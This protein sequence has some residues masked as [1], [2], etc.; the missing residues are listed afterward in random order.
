MTAKSLASVA[1]HRDVAIV[2]AAMDAIISFDRAGCVMEYNPAAE[3]LLGWTREETLGKHLSEL[4]TPEDAEAV[5]LTGLDRYLATGAEP[6]LDQRIEVPGRRR[7]GQTIHVEML[8]VRTGISD[9][10]GFTIFIRDIT[11]LVETRKRLEMSQQRFEAIVRHSRRI[12]ILCAS[13]TEPSH[14]IS[15]AEILGYTDGFCLANGFRGIVHPDDRSRVDRYVQEL[16]SR[17]TTDRS[18]D[19]R[20]QTATHEWRTCEVTGEDL[21]ELAAIGGLLISADDVT[22]ERA[23]RQQLKDRTAQMRALIN[24]LGSAVVLEDEHRHLLVVNERMTEMFGI[25]VSTDDLIGADCARSAEDVKHLFADPAG[26]VAR[27]DEVLASGER[28]MGE[29]L[30][31]AD[32]G[33]LERDYVPILS[34]QRS[35]GHLWVYRDITQQ[36]L[37]TQLLADQNRSLEEL[38]NLKNEFVARVSHELRSPLTSVASFADLLASADQ[39]NLGEDQQAFLDIIQRNTQ[40]LLR[41]IE[42]LLLVAKLESH[43]LPLSLGLIDLPSLVQQVVVE[44]QPQVKDSSTTMTFS[45]GEGPRVRGDAVRLQQVVTN[46]VRNALEYTPAGG[47]IDITAFPDPTTA[48]WAVIV[49]DTG[50][51]IDEEDLPHVF[52]AFYRTD[53]S[54]Q[55]SAKGTGLGLSIAHLITAEHG[56]SIEADST[57]GSGTTMTVRLPYGDA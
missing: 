18:I 6:L 41:L 56:G 32:G 2:Q 38:A 8:I 39:E 4:I 43:T 15:G 19:L 27:V 52:D 44:L 36:I 29:R 12:K 11:D 1:A 48:R 37:E 23:R 17:T 24:N 54:Q 51:G 33:T 5:D 3:R 46:L 14:V 45:S 42:D 53:S 7:D 50:I 21:S 49:T 34:G 35:A 40:R 10:E 13:P 20:L 30:L 16:R 28:Q 57:P 55:V 9:D 26:F 22:E 31:K 47:T 25:P